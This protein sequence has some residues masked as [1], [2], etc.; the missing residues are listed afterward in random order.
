[1]LV[2]QL[3]PHAASNSI[4]QGTEGSAGNWRDECSEWA[5]PDR[6]CSKRRCQQH[7]ISKPGALPACSEQELHGESDCDRQ[8]AQR[9]TL[10]SAAYTRVLRGPQRYNGMY[11]CRDMNGV[12]GDR[13]ALPL[14]GRGELRHALR[15][16]TLGHGS[17]QICREQQT[18]GGMAALGSQIRQVGSTCNLFNSNAGARSYHMPCAAIRAQNTA[19]TTLPAK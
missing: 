5:V 6:Q 15:R 16:S 8:A 18:S 3:A 19:T 12:C 7:Q 11:S 13:H 17:R 2:G 10:P 14:E 4:H 9:R 1:M